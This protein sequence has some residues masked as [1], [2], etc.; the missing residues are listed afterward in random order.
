[1]VD[2]EKDTYNKIFKKSGQDTNFTQ[3]A[4]K[5]LYR[6]LQNLLHSETSDHLEANEVLEV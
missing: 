5:E 1:M 6:A 3:A 4:Q 2:T